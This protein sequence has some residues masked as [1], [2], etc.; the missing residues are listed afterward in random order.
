MAIRPTFEGGRELAAEVHQR[1]PV[2]AIGVTADSG[3]W[4]NQRINPLLAPGIFELTGA[5]ENPYRSHLAQIVEDTKPW[6]IQMRLLPEKRISAEELVR[7]LSAASDSEHPEFDPALSEMLAQVEVRGAEELLIELRGPPLRAEAWFTLPL[8]AVGNYHAD[9]RAVN[10]SI[11]VRRTP[12]RPAAETAPIEVFEQTYADT[13]AALRGLLR[14]EVSIVD[15]IGP[16]DL[17]SLAAKDEIV[18]GQYA[19]PS[20]H[21][22]IPNPRRPLAANRALKRAILYGIDRQGILDRSLLAGQ[23]IAGC[24]VVSG[25]FPRGASKIDSRGYAYDEAVPARPYDPALALAL[26]RLTPPGTL[27]RPLVLDHPADVVPRVACQ[28]IARQLTAAGIP[29]TLREESRGGTDDAFDLRYV[30]LPMRE[31]LV[32]VWRLLGPR[33][34]AGPPSPAILLALRKLQDTGDLTTAGTRMKEI[35]ALAAAELPVIPLWQLVDHFAHRS[36]VKGI[37]KEPVSLYQ[38]IDQWQ[39]ELTLPSE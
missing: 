26:S 36:T 14:G 19:L 22:L 31:P 6:K 8:A 23:A 7:T 30:E 27:P 5:G 12:A 11:F 32:D 13:A 10:P 34:L 9:S 2:I 28:S 24:S 25:P 38:D 18:V 1:Y 29:V 37:G 39:V 20:V 16:W 3:D 33:G 4:A 21:V 17:K 35:H 15:R